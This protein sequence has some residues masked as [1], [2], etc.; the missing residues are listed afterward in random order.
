MPV[1]LI[2]HTLKRDRY[3]APYNLNPRFNCKRCGSNNVTLL[4]VP[5]RAMGGAWIKG[6]DMSECNYCGARTMNG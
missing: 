3:G 6:S 1:K 2:K 4:H 5:G